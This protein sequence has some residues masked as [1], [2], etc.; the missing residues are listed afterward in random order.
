[1]KLT[2]QRSVSTAVTPSPRVLQT[3]AMFGLG[4]DESHTAHI[5]PQTALTLPD[6]P[7]SHLIFITGPSGSGKSTILQL[8][9]E[10]CKQDSITTIA[11]DKL[12]P[13]PDKPLVD[14]FDLPIK[15]ATALLA[16]A[17]LSDAFVMLRTPSQLSDGQRYRLRLA[18]AMHLA[19]QTP[20]SIILADEFGAALDRLTAAIIARNVRKWTQR[21]DTIFICA[22]TH[23][24]LLAPLAPDVLIHKGLGDQ[25]TIHHCTPNNNPVATNQLPHP[26]HRLAQP[27]PSHIIQVPVSDYPLILEAGSLADYHTLADF[28]YKGAKPGAPTTVFRLIHKAPTVVGRYLQRRDETAIVGVLV[29]ALPHLACALRDEATSFRYRSLSMK[30]RAAMLNREIRTIARVVIHPQWRGLGLAVDL[31]RHALAHPEPSIIYTEA[32]AAMGHVHPFFDK[33]GMIRYQRPPRPSH[34]RL[35]D[36]LHHLGLDPTMLASPRLVRSHFA[37][38]DAHWKLFVRELTRWYRSGARRSRHHTASPTTPPVDD[39][40]AVARDQLITRPIYYLHRHPSPCPKE[41]VR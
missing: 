2:L 17:G 35:I 4:V 39:L 30:D 27:P 10:Q 24:D 26:E 18:H 16:M 32:L 34:A 21:N 36:A 9:T 20:R 8:I 23:D 22:T 1:M 37:S 7:A 5:V 28:H 11:F 25:I 33:A 13:L 38:R 15:K 31:V 12:P 14:V 6:P 19:Q 41:R 3:A 40:L 29:R